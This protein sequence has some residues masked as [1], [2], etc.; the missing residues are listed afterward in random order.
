MPSYRQEKIQRL[1]S[2]KARRQSLGAGILLHKA[3]SELGIIGAD[4]S[5]TCTENEKP[6][7]QNFPQI[8]FSLSHSG[9]YALC[10]L[11]D[12]PV[13]CD[14]EAIRP[15]AVPPGERF[16]CRDEWELIR[17]QPTKEER[18]SLFF[19]YWVL[20]ESYM[21]CTGL[22][23]ALPMNAFSV[24]FRSDRIAVVYGK[25]DAEYRFFLFSDPKDYACACCIKSRSPC[26]TPALIRVS[27]DA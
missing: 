6:F 10:A 9:D 2:E 20:K 21:K 14:I 4:E 15:L 22:G 16:F 24:R 26:K 3:C 23:F 25:D 17:K 27:F 5:M 8:S 13:G 7:F 1:R 12:C 18:E 19:R 11:S